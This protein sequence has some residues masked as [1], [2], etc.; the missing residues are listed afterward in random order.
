MLLSIVV[1][2]AFPQLTWGLLPPTTVLQCMSYVAG[3]LCSRRSRKCSLSCWLPACL[4]HQ[5]CGSKSYSFCIGVCF[6]YSNTFHDDPGF[7]GI[8]LFLNNSFWPSQITTLTKSTTQNCSKRGAQQTCSWP[9][10]YFQQTKS[11][12]EHGWLDARTCYA[13]PLLIVVLWIPL[14]CRMPKYLY[15]SHIMYIQA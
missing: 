6:K 15:S 14:S 12:S 5:L 8:V 4:L 1:I 10:P 7:L 11:S 9:L 3:T 13:V 2:W